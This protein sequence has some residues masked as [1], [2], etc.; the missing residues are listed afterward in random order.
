MEK[1]GCRKP[2]DFVFGLQPIRFDSLISTAA[3]EIRMLVDVKWIGL[4]CMFAFGPRS[5]FSR[6]SILYHL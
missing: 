5:V 3:T 2:H 1:G 6:S 4:P